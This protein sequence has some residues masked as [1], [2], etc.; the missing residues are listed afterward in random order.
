MRLEHNHARIGISPSVGR[1][2][3]WTPMTAPP[4]FDRAWL[5]LGSML[6]VQ[7]GSGV[8]GRLFDDVG[9]AAVVLIRQGGAALVLLLACRPSLRRSRRDWRT[10]VTFGLILATMNLSF[11]AAVERIPLG[12]AVTIELLGPL[13]LA[14]ALSRGRREWL[15]VGIAV[16]G[17]V[18]LGEAGGALDPVG[19]VLVLVA[20]ACWAAYILTSRRAGEQAGI[21]A[22]ALAM[23]VAAVAVAPLGL[24]AGSALVEP[25]TLVLG[26]LVAILAGLVPFSLELIALRHVPPRTFGVLMSI[27]PA[28]ATLSGFLLLDERL[29]TVQLA[30]IATVVAASVATVRAPVR[31]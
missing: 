20:A 2:A 19:I 8:A 25:R 5:L 28:A 16:A 3:G 21:D 29:T 1:G 31:P 18:L 4:A 26:A 23:S 7:V 14:A 17:V 13:G 30:G 11:Y 10:I 22:L 6:S 24:Q 12:I 15:W 9:P 27:S